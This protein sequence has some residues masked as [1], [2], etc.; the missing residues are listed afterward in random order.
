V[1]ITDLSVVIAPGADGGELYQL[2]ESAADEHSAA[3]AP[4]P[5]I[6]DDWLAPGQLLQ[7]E[8]RDLRVTRIDMSAHAGTHLVLPLH[9]SPGGRG[10]DAWPVNELC[11]QAALAGWREKDAVDHWSRVVVVVKEDPADPRKSMSALL[12]DVAA[13]VSALRVGD[14]PRLVVVGQKFRLDR[15]EDRNSMKRILSA[16]V[17]MVIGASDDALSSVLEGD[18]I[19]GLPLPMR[20]VEASPVRLVSLRVK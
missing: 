2:S 10:V 7:D 12:E 3:Y 19:L 20:D 13:R 5:V 4:P 14:R 11:G 8:A 17:P 6:F 1:Q 15:V 16:N 18:V 9:I